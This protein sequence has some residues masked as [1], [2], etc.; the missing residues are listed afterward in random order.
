MAKVWQFRSSLISAQKTLEMLRRSLFLLASENI[1]RSLPGFENVNAPAT[2]SIQKME[3]SATE[4]IAR[5][6]I[7][8]QTEWCAEFGQAKPVFWLIVHLCVVW[9]GEKE[10]DTD[11]VFSRSFAETSATSGKSMRVHIFSQLPKGRSKT[12]GT[13]W[14]VVS[15][16]QAHHKRLE[17][18]NTGG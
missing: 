6:R 4:F 16:H 11:V 17:Q 15:S 5:K 18:M 3:S 14:E 1:R 2:H 9:H 7:F 13:N 8:T 10:K 12:Q